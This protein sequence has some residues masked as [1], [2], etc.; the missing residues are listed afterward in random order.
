MKVGSPK[1]ADAKK[2][3]VEVVN[4]K[5]AAAEEDLHKVRLNLA[6]RERVAFPFSRFLH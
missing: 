3:E 2:L 4:A 1:D 6:A 5:A